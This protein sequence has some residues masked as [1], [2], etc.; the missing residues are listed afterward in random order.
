MNPLDLQSERFGAT[1]NLVASGA[2]NQLGRPA[3]DPLS[4]LLRETAQNSWDARLSDSETVRYG[5]SGY[6]LDNGQIDC[7]R[8]TV[9]RRV[10]ESLKLK[11]ILHGRSSVSVLAIH[12]RG[13]SG[14]GGPTRA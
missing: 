12:D 14:L 5:I 1:G 2:L 11:E 3:L 7:L 9:F 6:N 4:I 13:T 8:D 10:P